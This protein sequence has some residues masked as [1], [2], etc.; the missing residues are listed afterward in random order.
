MALEKQTGIDGSVK[1][2]GNTVQVSQWDCTD[3]VDLHDVTTTA[4]GGGK[5][6]ISGLGEA[7]GSISS[8]W[9]SSANPTA[10][11]PGI[12]PGATVA[13]ELF[14]G[15]IADGIK[16]NFNAKVGEVSVESPVGG[17]ITYNFTYES[18]GSI[19]RPS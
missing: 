9:D 10:V 15:P 13:L 12:I 19:T 6:K 2:G 16:Y 4:G 11:T 17:P 18:T 5:E 3:K 7:T 1:V 8:F 14:I